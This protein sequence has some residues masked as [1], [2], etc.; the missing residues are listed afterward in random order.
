MIGNSQYAVLVDEDKYQVN[1]G[2]KFYTMFDAKNTPIELS[3]AS[4]GVYPITS[5]PTPGIH[6]DHEG[7]Y[8]VEGS[9]KAIVGEEE[10]DLAP[11]IAFYA[12]AGLPHAIKKD[13]HSVDLKI[14]LFHFPV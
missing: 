4:L 12:P 2:A 5:Y 10:F 14:F 8:V 3:S 1:H 9:G 11:G 7:F 6:D 13:E